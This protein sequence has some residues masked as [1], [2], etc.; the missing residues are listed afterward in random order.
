M[1]LYCIKNKE[2]GEY[3]ISVDYLFF[4]NTGRAL[5]ARWGP[6][7]TY[8]PLRQINILVERLM[9][10]TPSIIDKCEIEVVE[11][12]HKPVKSLTT[13]KSVVSR[14]EQKQVVEKLKGPR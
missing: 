11:R 10:I 6:D 1:R 7:S 9:T 5:K 12:I 13:M 3:L 14:I 2:T 4:R 8:V